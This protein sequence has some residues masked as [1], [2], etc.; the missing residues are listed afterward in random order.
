MEVY[1]IGGVPASGKT[2]LV[3]KMI[4]E[5]KFVLRPFKHQKLKGLR[6][7]T[8]KMVI[9]GVY[10]KEVFSG[11]D[12]LPFDVIES[13]KDFLYNRRKTEYKIIFEGDRLFNM[14]FLSFCK[15]I[16]DLH[17]IILDID[18]SRQKIRF[19]KRGSDQNQVWLKGRETKLKGIKDK[20]DYVEFYNSGVDNIIEYIDTGGEVKK[21][22]I[23]SKASE[24]GI[25]GMFG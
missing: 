18:K 6:T 24:R 2:F 16:A 10:D 25:R 19:K 9:F 22:A 15:E 11:T 13:A 4:A 3:K 7:L 21:G 20:V 1:A 17:V 23:I 14:V 12:R 8:G 5:S